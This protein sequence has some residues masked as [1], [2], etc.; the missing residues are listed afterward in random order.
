MTD[1]K[2]RSVSILQFAKEKTDVPHPKIPLQ[3]YYSF[4]KHSSTHIGIDFL[5]NT[6]NV[7]FKGYGNGLS[8]LYLS[9]VI[10]YVGDTVKGI[11]NE[12]RLN[13]AYPFLRILLNK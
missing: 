11:N 10:L 13:V 4:Y 2:A 3:E 6:Q 1:P 12:R 5:S 7:E 9:G 8:T